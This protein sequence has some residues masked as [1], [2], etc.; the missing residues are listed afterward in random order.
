M[1]DKSYLVGRADSVRCTQTSTTLARLGTLVIL[2]C[3]LLC[4]QAAFA[5]GTT[6]SGKV[7]D[8]TGSG[9]PGVTVQI[10][11]TTK[12]TTTDGN[13]TYQLANVPGGST[14]VFSSIG[15]T[16][17][18]IAVGSRTTVDA[19][20]VED[21]KTLN[22]VV[23]VG[24]GTQKVKDATGSVSTLSTKEFNKGVIASPEQLLQGRVAGV[25][26]TPASGEPGAGINV[27]IRGATSLRAGN[28][29]LYVVDG[30]PLDGGDFNSGGVDVGAGGTSTPRN[31]LAF[32]NPND[33]ENISVL[34]DAS[35]AAI[36]G[37]RG[38]NGVI[39]ITT[40]KGK[41][42]QSQLNLSASTAIASPL[43]RYNLLKT[44]DFIAGVAAAG[45]N[46]TDGAVNAG[47]NTDW[48]DVLFR[49]S[50]S[51]IYNASFGG[52]TETTRYNFSLGYQDQQGVV[53]KTGQKRVTGRINASHD[54][55]NHKVTLAVNATTSNIQDQYTLNN[56]NAGYNGNIIGAVISA[57]PTYPVR[58]ADGTYYQLAGGGFRNPAAIL[59]Y[60]KDNGVT[61]RSLANA[62]ATWQVLPSVSLKANFGID[63]SVQTRSTS[64]DSRL[65][66]QLTGTIIPNVASANIF[67]DPTTGL[68][69]YAYVNN[70]T[71]LSKLVEYTANY[72]GTVG[73][74]TLE[75]LLGFS[76]QTF[77][78]RTNY[79]VA[80]NFPYNE[81]DIS[82]LDNLGAAATK[83][84]ATGA[85]ITSFGS[86]SSRSQNDL[87]S[88]FGRLNYNFLEK[89]L[90]T[91]TVRADGSSRFGVNNKYGVFPSIAGAWRLS[92][93][94]FIPKNIFNDLKLRANY[95][96]TGNQDF[97]GGAS[98]IIFTRNADGSQTQQNNPNP[99]LKWEQNTTIGA[100]I[101]FS[102][103]KGRL[104]GSIDYYNRSA[105]NTLFQVFY[106][107]PAP[108]Q[109]RFVN[110]PGSIV[111]NG[112]EL[113]LNFQA[114]QTQKFAWEIQGNFTTLK[115][116]VRNIGT[117]VT[118][119]AIDGQGLSGAY[120]QLVTNGYPPFAFFTPTF[121]GYDAN[122][123]STYADGG[124]SSYQGS[125]FPKARLGLT[126]NFTFG[127][128][129]AS[130]FF[131]GQVGGY[132]Y[133]NTANALFLKGSLKNGR[134]VDYAAANSVEN[135]LNPGSVSSRFIEKSDFL[136]LTN[137]N[138]GYTFDLPQGG[139][140]KTLNVSLTGQNLFILTPYSGL[141]PN[142]NTV[143]VLNNVP[144]LGIDYTPYPTPRTFTLGLNVGF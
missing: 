126:N 98:K 62:S 52:G 54:L 102:I 64:I 41:V 50:V 91:V 39:L 117:T 15:Y 32:L 112:I 142:V 128:L 81:A 45:G 127:R 85:A 130:V 76:Y 60:Y 93:E 139:F 135:G 36:Y 22:E 78:T 110:L 4:T 99:D 77:G 3:A 89:Y 17:Q 116:E 103:L 115:N 56:N 123:Y 106:A 88:Y 105:T 87:Q 134:N 138:I 18:E 26:I 49:T 120:A 30:V 79:Q 24:Y 104:S 33:I 5:Q 25:Q 132:I 108:V 40:R 55:F 75:G 107:Q 57:N 109:Y 20:L 86:G 2:L 10:K 101:D 9:L 122:G 35:A 70:L 96:I 13:G 90:V 143:K 74:G 121:T 94:S 136:R 92:Q 72:N 67:A 48:Q 14:L 1:M 129:N 63:N 12:G 71:R 114:V 68:G 61:N 43:N 66:A 82:Y 8:A 125:P 84:P 119:G 38:A 58:N 53:N 144:S 80:G 113:S 97:A 133:N 118:V 23:V 42:G 141:N 111:S 51:Q 34:K 65:N 16:S 37:A 131:D 47:G 95:G 137:L 140:A 6:I 59:E 46:A 7:I 83:N 73:P 124:A 27:Q 29:P 69:G 28:N 31:P 11:G 21:N 19:S 44:S 100:G